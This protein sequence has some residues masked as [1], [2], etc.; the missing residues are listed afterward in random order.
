MTSKAHYASFVKG[1]AGGRKSLF[2]FFFFKTTACSDQTFHS[3]AFPYQS[4]VIT[5]MEKLSRFNGRK[6][7]GL[8]CI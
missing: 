6:R 4:S 7:E 8:K 5:N 3:A 1:G 2:L